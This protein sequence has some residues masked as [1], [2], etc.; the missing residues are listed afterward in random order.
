MDREPNFSEAV[1]ELK[2]VILAE[3]EPYLLPIVEWLARIIRR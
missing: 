3:L 2:R 1:A